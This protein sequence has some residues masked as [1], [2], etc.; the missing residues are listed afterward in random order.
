MVADG[1]GGVARVQTEGA[2]GNQHVRLIIGDLFGRL[3]QPLAQPVQPS[4]RAVEHALPG[5]QT[6]PGQPLDPGSAPGHG[7][8]TVGGV[9]SVACSALGDVNLR[10]A[11]PRPSR[12]HPQSAMAAASVAAGAASVR[13]WRR[14]P[15]PSRSR[16]AA[17]SG[18]ANPGRLRVGLVTRPL[19]WS[20]RQS[21]S[22]R[23]AWSNRR[24]ACSVVR[25]NEEAHN[26]S[27][28]PRP[29][30][31]AGRHF[32]SGGRFELVGQ[33]GVGPVG[34]GHPVGQHRGRG[35][36]SGHGPVQVPAPGRGQVLV[37]GLAVEGMGVFDRRAR[38]VGIPA[39]EP[40]AEQQSR[41]AATGASTPATRPTI[42]RGD[43][44]LMTA[45]AAASSR[46]SSAG[47]TVGR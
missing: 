10:R 3:G 2:P 47:R 6:D 12:A 38:L 36:H 20:G 19:G 16:P 11:A 37:D 14:R 27:R 29:A 4:R 13:R 8:S 25:L 22:A 21:S 28:A 31:A 7:Q 18:L 41:T 46:A 17:C 23:T 35:Q 1:A 9:D 5:G 30:C 32:S 24:S 40:G 15:V 33:A 26:R 43:R 42:G 44:W 45:M 34:G 39:D